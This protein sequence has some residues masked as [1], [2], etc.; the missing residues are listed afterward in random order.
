MPN[1]ADFFATTSSRTFTACPCGLSEL[2]L[3]S[4]WFKIVVAAEFAGG[5]TPHCSAVFMAVNNR[6]T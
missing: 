5:G 3:P 1:T 2:C 4:R 6:R